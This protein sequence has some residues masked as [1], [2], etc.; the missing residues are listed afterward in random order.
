M[1]QERNLKILRAM[2]AH[3]ENRFCFDCHQRGPTYVN[4]TVGSFVCTTCGGAL[5][6]YNHRVKSIS[7]SNF[8]QSEMD[9]LRKRGNKACRKIYLAL[10]DDQGFVE[11]ELGDAAR[12]EYLRQKYQMQ[13]WYREPTVDL[14]T[15]AIQENQ[16]ILD[17]IDQGGS[18]QKCSR[19]PPTNAAAGLLLP[20]RQASVSS[21]SIGSTS[22][23]S[24]GPP[25][26]ANGLQTHPPP[27]SPPRSGPCSGVQLES[28]RSTLL[29]SSPK[30]VTTVEDPFA[31]FS[32]SSAPSGV[33]GTQ[34]N[35][36]A[37][38]PWGTAPS[39]PSP[40]TA[41][42]KP[43]SESA[44]TTTFD[45]LTNAPLNSKRSGSVF[46]PAT[47]TGDKYAALAELDGLL[48]NAVASS[49]P[50]RPESTTVFRF[51][52][53]SAP[54]TSPSAPFALSSAFPTSTFSSTQM[55]QQSQNP[56]VAAVAN[57]SSVP[58][59]YSASNPFTSPVPPTPQSFGSPFTTAPISVPPLSAVVPTP[60]NPFFSDHQ[61]RAQW[62]SNSTNPFSTAEKSGTSNGKSS[63]PWASHSSGVFNPSDGLSTNGV[64]PSTKTEAPC[65]NPQTVF[66]QSFS[67]F[68][69]FG[70]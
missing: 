61:L 26:S 34:D 18:Q 41:L 19:N 56:F 68:A 69:P 46:P 50:V 54:I 28:S 10:S 37:D 14:D 33:T 31:A 17:R 52:G 30:A 3:E 5:R 51:P 16:Q 8:S 59:Q 9:F 62:P 32:V 67:D 20:S 29:V 11:K 48:K 4:I 21:S 24:L 13:K 55:S 2:V 6:K 1:M 38:F 64:F 44:C 70:R 23:A 40:N 25:V 58:R 42:T 53:P 57:T 39:I 22:S 45:V 7:M 36:F 27:L 35:F 47:Q 60:R 66:D 43:F 12:D 63:Y 15:E 65:P 49:A